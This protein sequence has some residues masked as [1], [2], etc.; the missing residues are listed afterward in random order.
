MTNEAKQ[1]LA[2]WWVSWAA[3][4]G[5]VFAIYHF[6]DNAAAQPQ[7]PSG[8]SP[9]WLAGLA[10][11]VVSTII[12]WLVLPR[13]RSVQAAFPLFILGIASAEAMCFLGLFIFP[14]HKQGLFVL[15]VLG[16]L[17]FV[18]YFARRYFTRDGQPP[19]A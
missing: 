5:G 17:Q 9:I 6:L 18:P 8:D 14:A 3:F 4:L 15:S 12:R 1:P 19:R 2:I 16:M 10:P 13:A 7:A 11:F